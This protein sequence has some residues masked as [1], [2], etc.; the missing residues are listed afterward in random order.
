[1]TAWSVLIEATGGRKPAARAIDL[2]IDAML[3]HSGSVT[4]PQDRNGYSARLSV[5]ASTPEV[6]TARAL[7]LFR[8]SAG[9][10]GLPDAPIVRVEA[11]TEAELDRELAKPAFP[12]LVGV[13]E[14]AALLGVTRQRASEV[15]NRA[16]FPSPVAR[17]KSGPVWTLASISRFVETWERRAG[18]PAAPKAGSTKKVRV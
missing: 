14:I 3:D 1:M 9:E 15:Q 8:G 11:L 5:D 4:I 7:T 6:A 13:T 18:R 10:A 17:L 2:F 12:E 16:G